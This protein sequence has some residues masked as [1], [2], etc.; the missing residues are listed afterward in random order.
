MLLLSL[1]LQDTATIPHT[2][3]NH[4]TRMNPRLL[5]P[6]VITKALDMDMH[7]IRH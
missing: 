7:P 4:H 2:L 1:I 3:L 6:T 5:T